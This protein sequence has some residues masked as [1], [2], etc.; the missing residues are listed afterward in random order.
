[1]V[2]AKNQVAM[3]SLGRQFSERTVEKEYAAIVNGVPHPGIGRVETEI[4]RSSHDRKKMSVNPSSGG[5]LA[6]TNYHIAEVLGDFCLLRVKIET[7][8]TH[9]IRVHM[10]HIGH[11]IV[12]D[13]V[14][15]KR[16]EKQRLSALLA[17]SGRGNALAKRQ[18]LHAAQLQLDHPVSGER[19]CFE[20]PLADD[21][22][23]ML[24]ALRN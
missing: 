9:Q 13:A 11:H 10:A 2:V 22:Q 5:R 16:G 17:E 7:G 15:G 1:M 24:E 3:D 20:A 6:I 4:G 19:C 8:R 12:G 18:M 21:M 23:K 14:Y